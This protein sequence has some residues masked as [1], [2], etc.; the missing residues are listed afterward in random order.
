[1]CAK[2]AFRGALIAFSLAF[3]IFFFL[4]I[5][6]A[7]LAQTV[8]TADAKVVRPE[9]ITDLSKKLSPV[10]EESRL[11]FTDGKESVAVTFVP[12]DLSDREIDFREVT[13]FR[14]MAGIVE[15]GYKWSYSFVLPREDFKASVSVV[16]DKSIRIVNRDYLIIDENKFM[17]F[18]DVLANGFTYEIVVLNEREAQ[19]IF[20]KDWAKAGVRVGETVLIDPY[21]VSYPFHDGYLERRVTGAFNVFLT[22]ATLSIGN[23]IGAGDSDY[24]YRAYMKFNTT[25]IDPWDTIINATF[26]G[27]VSAKS[28]GTGS[29]RFWLQN[30]SDYGDLGESDWDVPYQNISI[31][32][33]ANEN[34]SATWYTVVVTNWITKAGSTFYRLQGSYEDYAGVDCFIDVQSNESINEPYVEIY[35]LDGSPAAPNITIVT[36]VNTSYVS[37]IISLQVSSNGGTGPID[38]WWYS[39]NGGDNVT[40]VPNN[41]SFAAQLGGNCIRVW[42]NNTYGMQSMNQTCF[43]V[44]SYGTSLV[45]QAVPSSIPVGS[46]LM[47]RCNY[48]YASNGSE[49]LGATCSA[50]LNESVVTR[51]FYQIDSEEALYNTSLGGFSV[52]V[53]TLGTNIGGGAYL[54]CTNQTTGNFTVFGFVSSSNPF[55]TMDGVSN[56]TT[57]NYTTLIGSY[58]CDLLDSYFGV[59]GAVLKPI[60]LYANQTWIQQSLAGLGN[61]SSAYYGFYGGCLNCSGGNDVW[62]VGTDSGNS[63]YTYHGNLSQTGNWSV[64]GDEH[65]QWLLRDIGE[66]PMVFNATTGFY[67]V[68]YS[69]S[70]WAD[71][72]EY[73]SMGNC[74][75]SSFAAKISTYAFILT[76]FEPPTCSIVSYTSIVPVM[77]N[78]T[79]TWLGSSPIPLIERYAILK[80]STGDALLTVSDA[81]TYGLQMNDTGQFSI[82]CYVRN[83]VGSYTTDVAFTVEAVQYQ[84]LLYYAPYAVVGSPATISA[85]VMLGGVPVNVT[86]NITIWIDGSEAVMGWVPADKAYEVVWIP[87]ANG[88]YPFNVSGNIPML[89]VEDGLIKVRTPF[90]VTVRL[91]NNINMSPETS[92]KNEFAWVYMTKD[93]DPTLHVLF[94]RNKYACPP[95]GNDECFWHAAY[96]DGT[97][98]VTLFEEGNYT[99]YIL[100][101]NIDWYLFSPAGIQEQ[102]DF[103]SPVKTQSRFLLNLGSYYFMEPEELDL[104]YSTT[105]LYY[106]G[107]FFGA[108][109][110]WLNMFLFAIIG[111]VFFFIVLIATGSLKSAIAVL[112]ILPSI[113]WIISNVV[114]W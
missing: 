8:L 60:T 31:F 59:K 61:P 109:A 105:E 42:L 44:S 33:Y 20:L 45:C 16:A 77:S 39:L 4:I 40:F 106:L 76:G 72:K 75:K 28:C 83:I 79:F 62:Y 70:E 111:L 41:L 63:G 102:C 34:S 99:M 110:S 32:F 91:W 78:Q 11:S 95:Q 46:S 104:F 13:E 69:F 101:N 51:R 52:F 66:L 27:R 108:Y 37:E 49:V 94:G 24:N 21:V 112:I 97:A 15:G 89:V 71:V 100:G 50:R 87:S 85:Y 81:G 67:E 113:L 80:N 98:T 86:T 19:V 1:M 96:D 48:T 103:C 74:S 88:D 82:M 43:T 54:R 23:N 26:Y 3:G 90:N 30:I 58:S 9:P 55:V 2:A 5:S 38:R 22:D 93:V 57:R 14:T 107:G 47:N 7:A 35:Y 25:F 73:Y 92:Y 64:E 12:R 56:I 65:A 10:V 6:Q 68:P 29:S 17:S 36:P 53:P 114:L 84:L 18:E